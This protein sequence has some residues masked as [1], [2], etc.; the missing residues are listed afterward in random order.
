MFAPVSMTVASG[1]RDSDPH[2]DYRGEVCRFFDERLSPAQKLGVIHRTMGG[3]LV[4]VRMSFERIE[5]FFASLSAGE[6]EE[7]SLSRAL[8]EMARDRSARGR[9]LALVR[10]TEDPAIRVRMIALARTLGWLSP[11]D[12]R[13]ELVHMILDVLASN[14][15]S[16]GEVDLI[17]SMN[18]DRDL[19]RELHR[20][21]VSKLPVNDTAYAAARACLGSSE[22]R[23]RVLR[24][25]ASPRDQDVQIAQAYLRH[26]PITDTTELH[27]VAKGIAHMAGSAAQVR[28]LET[29]ARQHISD[30]E[31][32]DELAR[33][34][35]QAT[36]VSVQRAIAEIFIRSDQRSIE[37]PE[38][39][40]L[41]RRHRLQSPD[42]D[43]LIDVLIGRLQGS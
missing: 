22:G 36:S 21:K 16:Y 34:F 33:L 31:I 1:L 26:H 10:D 12:Q 6:R 35:V 14:S 39:L 37:T 32:L 41:L 24:A 15:A 13:A 28:A 23:A 27:A 7:A 25:L 8:A 17:C 18:R 38:F 42:G 5:K 11:A 19:D 29:L 2:A 3:D 30:R 43:D 40:G 20:L 4:E 9:Y